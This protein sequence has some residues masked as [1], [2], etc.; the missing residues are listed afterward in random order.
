MVASGHA[1]ERPGR[2]H[3]KIT[4]ALASCPNSQLGVLVL[5]VVN[6]IGGRLALSSLRRA[7]GSPNG[8]LLR[9]GRTHWMSID[10][11]SW[12]IDSIKTFLT[13]RADHSDPRFWSSCARSAHRVPSCT[14]RKVTQQPSSHLRRPPQGPVSPGS[15]AARFRW[16][17]DRLPIHLVLRLRNNRRSRVE[18]ST[19]QSR[20]GRLLWFMDSS[21]AQ[22]RT[23]KR[24][25][26]NPHNLPAAPCRDAA[27]QD[28]NDP[29]WPTAS[30]APITPPC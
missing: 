27:R 25:S 19:R 2:E 8:I 28:T 5:G 17:A 29:T 26:R 21:L 22:R 10:P 7:G 13:C 16:A 20:W 14:S 9:L 30:T 6:F 1:C 18:R 24:Y 3:P 15:E 4:F 12:A 23:V 11:V